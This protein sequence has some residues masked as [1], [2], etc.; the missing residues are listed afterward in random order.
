MDHNREFIMNRLR[1]LLPIFMS[2]TVSCTTTQIQPDKS[3]SGKIN[4]DNPDHVASLQASS[5]SISSW[6][7]S[8]AIAARN[9]RKSWTASLNWQQHGAEQYQIR[10]FGPLGGGTVIIEKHGELISYYDGPKKISSTNADKL[11]L[12]QTGV[13][14]PV[15]NL[16]YWVRAIPAPGTIHA[17][18]YLDGHLLSRLQQN[19]FTVTYSQYTSVNGIALP[20]KIRLEG[21]GM[22]IK[23]VIKHWK[24]L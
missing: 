15:S 11:L 5:Q 14:L 22:L 18:N 13:K 6:E 20:S 10:L 19:G 7:I 4:T 1:L 2:L 17:K 3:L 16:Y 8:G 23:L 12:Q 21:S 9:K 24:F